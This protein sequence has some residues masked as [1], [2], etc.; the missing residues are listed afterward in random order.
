MIIII[1]DLGQLPFPSGSTVSIGGFV[2]RKAGGI[3]GRKNLPLMLLQAR[4]VLLQHFRPIFQQFGLTEQQWR[5]LR[6]VSDREQL[7]QREIT[8]LCQISGPSLSNILSRLEEVGYVV[9]KRSKDDHRK[10]FVRLGHRGRALVSQVAPH[11]DARYR[12]LE[13]TLGL[14][15]TSSLFAV[16]ERL[17]QFPLG[18]AEGD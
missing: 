16:L 12:E 15:L 1:F 10:V 7:E 3:V 8:I 17:L 9:R 4:E 2:K 18:S 13:K 6:V 11:V 5:I 14:E